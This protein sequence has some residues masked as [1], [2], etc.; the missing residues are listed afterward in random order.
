MEALA[1]VQG[2]LSRSNAHD[3]VDFDDLI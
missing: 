2:L 3:R 1:R